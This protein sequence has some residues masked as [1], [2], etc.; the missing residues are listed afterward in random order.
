[1]HTRQVILL[2]ILIGGVLSELSERLLE[3]PLVAFALGWI[4]MG[5][6]IWPPDEPQPDRSPHPQPETRSS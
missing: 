6:L 3:V 4:A 5:A 1:M 2:G